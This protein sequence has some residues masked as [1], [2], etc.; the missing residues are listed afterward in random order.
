MSSKKPKVILSTGI[1]PLHLVKSATFLSKICDIVVIQSWIPKNTKSWFVKLLSNLVGHKHLATGVKKRTPPELNNKNYSCALPEFLLWGLNIISNKLN[2]PSKKWNAGFAWKLY[3]VQSKKYIREANIFHVR[4]GA[5]QGNAIS[6]AKKLGMKILVDHSIAHPKFMDK[7][8]A[9]IFKKYNVPFG[10]G[11]DSP[12]FQYAV[13]DAMAADFILVN[14][15]FVKKTFVEQGYISNK[16]KVVYLGVRQDFMGLKTNYTSSEKIKLLFTGGFGFRKGGEYLLKALQI[17]E[18]EGVEF[19]MK[20]VGSYLEA[21]PIIEKYPIKGIEFIGFIPQDQL[22]Q[23]LKSADMYIFPS[24][25]EGCASSG[26]EAMAAGLPVIATEESGF[27]IE[28]GVDGVIIPSKDE[29][30][31]YEAIKELYKN[32]AKRELLGGNAAHKIKT[33]YTWE[34]YAANVNEIYCE[35]LNS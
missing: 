3:G 21:L 4:S 19:E 9:P 12:L 26:M 5:G 35:L 27:P 30:S 18:K 1:G 6:Y 8:L 25:C 7:N 10:L 2:Y 22:K 29:V 14:S 34:Q 13:K 23:Y 28:N 32:P 15:F 17:L 11:M 33:K 24:L 31:I 20:I 16:I